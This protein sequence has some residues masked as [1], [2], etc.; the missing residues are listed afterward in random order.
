MKKLTGTKRGSGY[1]EV[2]FQVAIV[3]SLAFCFVS[4]WQPFIYKQNVDYMA[5]TLVRAIE[6]NGRIDASI[7]DLERQLKREM[8]ISPT[9][10]YNAKYVPGTNKIQ[11]KE[12]FSV[13]VSDTVTVKLFEPSF[14]PPIGIE[15]PINKKFT[16]ISQVFWKTGG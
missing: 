14:G 10:K 13:T 3:M 6:A 2:L 15:I 4:L 7:T 8:G 5:K 12:K 9:V 11:I 16:G 1:V